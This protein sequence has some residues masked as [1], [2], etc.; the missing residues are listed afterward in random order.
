MV[1]L[2]LFVVSVI[3]LIVWYQLKYHKRNALFAK[4]PSPKKYPLIH[5]IP[6]F[7]GL[8]S[9]EVFNLLEKWHKQFGQVF[10]TTFDPFDAGFGVITNPKIV[11][12]IL[13]SHKNLDKS[14]DYNMLV[15]WLGTG[16]LTSTGRKW[17][18][19]RKI[20]TPTFHFKILDEVIDNS[21]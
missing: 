12:A 3:S 14:T 6:H 8:D 15:R 16:L 2:S 10:H 4:I 20:I 7:F 19:R 1:F 11:E 21:S 17:H 13:T 5:N 9:V 18:Q